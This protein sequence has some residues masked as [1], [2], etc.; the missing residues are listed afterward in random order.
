MTNL[1]SGDVR[2]ASRWITAWYLPLVI[3]SSGGWLKFNSVAFSFLWSSQL[4]YDVTYLKYGVLLPKVKSRTSM[5]PKLRGAEIVSSRCGRN[6][7]ERKRRNSDPK[8]SSNVRGSKRTLGDVRVW[9]MSHVGHT[10]ESLSSPYFIT[11]FMR[12]SFSAVSGKTEH[13]KWKLCRRNEKV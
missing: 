11:Y 6:R 5:E 10:Q 13:G 2:P 1:A 4:S 9:F 12:S 3:K 8:R 7:E